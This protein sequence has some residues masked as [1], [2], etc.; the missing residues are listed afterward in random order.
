[1][2]SHK[3]LNMDLRIDH[4]PKVKSAAMQ[5][6]FL[7]KEGSTDGSAVSFGD[8]GQEVTLPESSRSNRFPRGQGDT[9]DS[10][11]VEIEMKNLDQI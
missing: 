5:Q 6:A 1:M 4:S 10:Y 9:H 11:K 7:K 3:V 8:Q 2:P